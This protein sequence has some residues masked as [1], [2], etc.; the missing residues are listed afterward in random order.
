MNRFKLLMLAVGLQVATS[1]GA[2]YA[3][4][5]PNRAEEEAIKALMIQTTEA[6][7]KHDAKAWTRFCTPD[8][9]LVTVRG[10]SMKGITEIEKG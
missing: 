4:S 8:A 6:F 10:E 5:L 7:N 9:Q 1:G 3:Q 2:A